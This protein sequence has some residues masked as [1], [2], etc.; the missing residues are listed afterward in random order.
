M[1]F[2]FDGGDEDASARSS[3]A[4]SPPRRRRRH[5]YRE[6]E[7]KEEDDDESSPSS[8]SSVRI[9]VKGAGKSVWAQQ[10]AGTYQM[11][12]D[13]C[14]DLCSTIL[15]TESVDA[16]ID[17]AL[18]LANRKTRSVLWQGDKQGTEEEDD[19]AFMSSSSALWSQILNVFTCYDNNNNNKTKKNKKKVLGVTPIVSLQ[20]R[21]RT[22]SARR[23]ERTLQMGGSATISSSS[24]AS[25]ELKQV[26]A[27]LLSFLSWDCT[28]D[29]EHS[30]AAMGRN[31]S[32]QLARKVR[33]VILQH[34]SALKGA[35]QVLC[36]RR[37]EQN[38][39]NNKHV[40]W[41][42]DDNNGTESAQS[43]ANSS[44]TSSRDHLRPTRKRRWS[45]ASVDSSM[46]STISSVSFDE[47]SPAAAAAAV[48]PKIGDPTAAGRRKRR[49]RRI[50]EPIAENDD[51]WKTILPQPSR[52][53]KAGTP[54]FSFASSENSSFPVPQ[55]PQRSIAASSSANFD[56]TTSNAKA[57]PRLERL[58]SKVT[59]IQGCGDDSCSRMQ[60]DSWIS[61]VCLESLNRIINGKDKDG[62]SCIE[63]TEDDDDDDEDDNDEEVADEAEDSNPILTTNN[64][65][66]K[67]GVVPHLA[68]AMSESLEEVTE[69]LK[70][71]KQDESC[72]QCWVAKLSIL[73]SLIDGACL[74][75]G[76][77]RRAF[78]EED[79]FSFEK[80]NKGLVFHIVL[81]LEHFA[82]KS[83][84]TGLDEKLSEIVL[85]GLRTLTSLTHDNEVA[86]EQLA[87]RTSLGEDEEESI[88]GL[89]VLT[90][91]VFELEELNNSNDMKPDSSHSGDEDLHRYDSTVF[92]LNTL[93][94]VVEGPQVRQILAEISVPSASGEI[95]W[96]KWLCQWLVVQTA[97][98]RDALMGI[99]KSK[100]S[101]SSQ[102]R[103]LQK[104]EEDKLVAAGN[105]CVLLA[106]LMKEPESIA[107]EP[108]SMNTIRNTII[109]Q[110]PVD[111]DGSSTGLTMIVNTLKAF[112]NFY[113]YSLGGFSVAIV[114]PVKK[115][116]LELEEIEGEPKIT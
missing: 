70:R 77:N 58:I 27:C 64:L 39:N 30:V 49:K 61:M 19:L 86:R 60:Q 52:T 73:A 92:C 90:D 9:S 113:H 69:L 50:M 114:A 62:P 29:E 16:A 84:Q 101:A 116:I 88:C 8:A 96:I 104:N 24:G 108:E 12:H 51:E 26:L 1:E 75:H 31:K 95:L 40:T 85:L 115:L 36:L 20:S 103:E 83:N 10:D 55:S 74:F 68:K 18:L 91:L 78:C 15:S 63:R 72:L 100:R 17:L 6:G 112:C 98:F 89:E 3:T 33:N 13:E 46:A 94:N 109:D 11:L 66:A 107:E 67:S 7:E 81:M 43:S 87:M 80:R 110:M 97:S 34:A 54:D 48:D 35:V 82:T 111:K 21:N 57:L 45:P 53:R 71:D 38:N 79:P 25:T 76:V 5:R 23:K 22:K 105:G 41:N 4:S 56:D 32:P 65:L 44:P 28:L 59:V 102:Q 93:A 47:P 99:G 14:S 2:D 106:C 42:T 37:S